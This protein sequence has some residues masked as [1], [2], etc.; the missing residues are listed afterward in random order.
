M[1]SISRMIDLVDALPDK[2]CG[3]GATGTEV[4]AAEQALGVHLPASYKAFLAKFGWAR[5]HYDPVYGVG[6]S[7]PR[8][9]ELVLSTQLERHEA[10][11]L[12]PLPLI[13]VMN[14]GAG[15]HYC[16]DTARLRDGECPVVFWDHEH[17]DESDQTPED[18]APSFDRWLINLILDV[19]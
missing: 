14:D 13:P 19:P 4:A 6:S 16:L 11:P 18:V 9:Y 1:M 10:Y 3:R 8:E 12:I 17:P 2:E 5:I 7:V 15:N